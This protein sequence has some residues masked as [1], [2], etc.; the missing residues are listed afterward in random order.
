[1]NAAGL[2]LRSLAGAFEQEGEQP[3]SW[4]DVLASA[5]LTGAERSRLDKQ[6]QAGFAAREIASA[7]ALGYTLIHAMDGAFRPC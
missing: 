4:D 3:G 1:M 6:H 2:T 5:P 7:H